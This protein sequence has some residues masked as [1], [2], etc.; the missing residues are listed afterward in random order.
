[1]IRNSEQAINDP[2]KGNELVNEEDEEE[3]GETRCIC[4]ELDPPDDSGLYIQC[5]QCGVWQ[6]G[7]CVGISEGEDSNLDKYWCEQCKPEL[8]RLYN[9]ESTGELRSVYKPIQ[10]KKSQNERKRRVDRPRIT[11]KEEGKLENADDDN[12]NKPD[13]DESTK[14]EFFDKDNGIVDKEIDQTKSPNKIEQS[15]N[16]EILTHEDKNIQNSISEVTNYLNTTTDTTNDI[17]DYNDDDK[18]IQDRKRATSSAREEKQYRLML[19]KAIKESKRTSHNTDEEETIENEEEDA[20]GWEDNAIEKTEFPENK[21][22]AASDIKTKN[23]AVSPKTTSRR[24]HS[25]PSDSEDIPDEEAKDITSIKPVSDRKF[26]VARRSQRVTKP[27]NRRGGRSSS[28]TPS[29]SMNNSN[30]NS[31]PDI[32]KPVKP[33]LPPQRTS[34]NE[35]RR[36]VAAILEFISRTQW[37]LSQEQGSKNDLVRFVENQQFIKQVDDIYDSYDGS[38]KLMDDLTRSLLLWEKKYSNEAPLNQ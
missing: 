6:H 16:E 19:E 8:H 34:L 26:V 1:M 17:D 5:E 12:P 24:S 23:S 35:M 27:T 4:G 11:N 2:E 38:L 29:V 9:V 3:E 13:V 36:R 10:E 20:Y 37:E 15:N 7:F 14:P 32:N 22:E 21:N 28:N 33:R 31:E 18:K 25:Y 30:A